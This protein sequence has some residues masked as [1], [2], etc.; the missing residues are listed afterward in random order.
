MQND[1]KDVQKTIQGISNKIPKFEK[2]YS[3]LERIN[4]VI[5]DQDSGVCATLRYVAEQ[6]ESDSDEFFLY[7]IRECSAT[8]K[9][10]PYAFHDYKYGSKDA[11]YGVR[12]HR[13]EIK[14]KER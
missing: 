2:L 12:N 4:S 13:L 1:L 5:E 9:N 11:T 3:D 14:V 8:S 6:S 10:N 7:A